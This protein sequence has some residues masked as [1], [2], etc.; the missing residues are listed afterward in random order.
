MIP[1]FISVMAGIGA[2]VAFAWKFKGTQF[3]RP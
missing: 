2:M 1:Q 3:C